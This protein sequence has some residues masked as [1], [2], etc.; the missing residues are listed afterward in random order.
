MDYIVCKIPRWDLTKFEKVSRKIG[1]A[2]KSVGEVMSIGRT[3]E[4]SLQKAMRMVDNS[5]SGFE[6]HNSVYKPESE[7]D[8]IHELQ[9]P[10][11]IRIYAIAHAMG[12]L[13]WSVERV[14][15]LTNIDTWFLHKLKR[16][17]ELDK[18]LRSFNNINEVN[19]T[20][21]LQAKKSGF[22]DK[23][24]GARVGNNE[25]EVRD[26]RKK[27]GIFP[28]VKQIDTMAGEAPAQTNYL[29]MTYN[30]DEHDI[31]FGEPSKMVL[32]SGTYRI[33]S[34]V[35]FDWCSVSAIRTL[36]KLGHQA[37]VVNYNPETVSTDYDECD[38]MY[39]EELSL[40]RVLDIYEQENCNQAII[41]VGGQTPNNLA[42]PLYENGV[43]IA[44]TSPVMI[45]SAEDRDKFSSLCDKYGIDQPR[46]QRL[47]SP[48]DAF[49]FA[50]EVGYPIL[51]RPSYVLSGAAMNV[52]YTPAEL[53]KSLRVAGEI[54]NEHPVVISKFIEGGREIDIDAVANNG[55]VVCH[56]IS[57]HV[58]NAGVH[59]GDATLI[60]P[61]QGLSEDTLAKCRETCGKIAEAL[62]ITGPFNMQLIAKD[63]QVMIIETN[64]RA[65]R[66][67]PFS[68]KTVGGDFIEAA[69][70]IMTGS[71]EPEWLKKKDFSLNGKGSYPETY[72]GVKSPMFSF[73]RLLGA[74]PTLGVEMASTGEVACYGEDF[75]EAFVKSMLSTTG[76]TMPKN[77]SVL[78]SIQER[79]RGDFKTSLEKLHE[80]GFTLYAT[81]QTAQYLE[82][83]NIPCT[84]LHW[85]ESGMSP[86]ID[87]H[88]R[89]KKI[90]MV[91]MF[92]NNFSVRTQT[93]YT[94]RRVAIDFG[95]PLI[96]NLQVAEALANSFEKHYNGELDLKVKTLKEYYEKEG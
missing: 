67:F 69:T 76:F 94:I 20:L 5:I 4:E 13:G 37:V 80:M 3:F 61:P 54:S 1:S 96:T 49:D 2:M 18:T 91:F 66:S 48:E 59:S 77:K 52:A 87:E 15:E 89:S 46:W 34:S 43:V 50:D 25:I 24:I 17:V 11:D 8:L 26:V 68:S 27:A 90:D 36:R 9:S 81:E 63:D 21:L 7:E 30:G 65:S 32:G 79:L 92:A 55:K 70:S 71:G 86:S 95:V 14:H 58:E 44:G 42:M 45:D 72:V 28:V 56:A 29:Y 82:S 31:E 83:L 41:S 16:I 57:E 75:H 53:S 40:E 51:V 33:G 6:I 73:K 19:G 35:E 47:T 64:L 22:S 38:K 84:L 74:D 88:L 23:Q 10:S 60:L 85:E 39:F 78:V 62:Q 93:N 12:E